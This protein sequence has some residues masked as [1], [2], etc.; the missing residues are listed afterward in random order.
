MNKYFKLIISLTAVYTTAFFGSYFTLPSIG[1][2][3][4]NL[5]KPLFNPPNWIFGPVWSILY[6]MIAISFY[7][8]WK[9]KTLS[10]IRKSFQLFLLQLVLNFMWSLLFFG[11]HQPLLAFVDIILLWI[12]ILLMI[13][14]FKNESKLASY[15]L[16]PYLFWVTFASILNLSIVLLN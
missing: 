10:R 6:L 3:Y 15:L 14:E 13:M 7:L 9:K 4:L 2:W 11:L 12:F 5:N 1:S 8:V 16:I